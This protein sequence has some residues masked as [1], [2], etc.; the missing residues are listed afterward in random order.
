MPQFNE[1]SA[2]LFTT[3]VDSGIC[4]PEELANLMGNATVETGR[5]RRMHESFAYSS[6]D[7]VIAAVASADDRF[8][9]QEVEAA[10]ASGDPKQIA[11]VMYE[12]RAD[13]GNAEL[14]DGWR[15]HGRGY[16]Q[17][18]GRDNYERYGERF[19]VDLA[20]NP[21]LAAD[22]QTAARLAVAYWQD[23]V[24]EASRTDPVAA[25]RIINGGDNGK[26]AR[27]AASRD[28]IGT[29]TPEL[30]ED[31]RTGRV[32]LE[33]LATLGS[34]VRNPTGM[35]QVDSVLARPDGQGLFAVQGQLGDPASQRV[36]VDRAQAVGQ[37][38]QASTRQL[39]ALAQVQDPVLAQAQAQAQAQQPTR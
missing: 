7:N 18:T 35:R 9:W 22:P 12:N 27:V 2:L 15:F 37:D 23:R 25:G 6:A 26:D 30:V 4:S 38:V 3:A 31:V 21:D 10:V 1:S 19:G 32:T 20:N 39:E 16:L 17:Y 13:L 5:F 29:I 24:P 36:Y 8:T 11:K 33:Q 28:W 14:G 34:N